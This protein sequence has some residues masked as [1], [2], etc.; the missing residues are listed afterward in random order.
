MNNLPDDQSNYI[1]DPLKNLQQII[2]SDIENRIGQLEIAHKKLGQQLNNKEEIINTLSPVLSDLLQLTIRDSR[3]EIANALSP[4]MSKAIKKQIHDSKEEVIDALYPIVGRMIS[5][6]I[7]EALKGLVNSINE[8]INN[9]Y[10]LKI[11]LQR[12]KAKIF[13]V[14]IGELIIAEQAPFVIRDVFLIARESGL[15]IAHYSKNNDNPDNAHIVAAM[16]TAIKSFVQDAFAADQASELYEIEYSD[17]TIR[18]E[19]GLYAY[20]AIVYRGIAPIGL[21][22]QLTQVQERIH[23]KYS[24]FLRDYQGENSRLTKIETIFTEFSEKYSQERE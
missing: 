8:N 5:K 10:N 13:G 24:R 9:K 1:P 19:P 15:L 18:I 4:V 20:L 23:N 14:N 7:A 17:Q 2:L 6:A 12:L 16:L 3:D 21:N 22:E 11:W